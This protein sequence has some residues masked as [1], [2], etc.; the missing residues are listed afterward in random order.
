MPFYCPTALSGAYFAGDDMKTP[1][2]GHVAPSASV[3]PTCWFTGCMQQTLLFLVDWTP[4]TT[5][6]KYFAGLPWRDR[7]FHHCAKH[8]A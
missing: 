2:R 3:Q 7:D 4:Q 8:T 6:S 5:P 1:W